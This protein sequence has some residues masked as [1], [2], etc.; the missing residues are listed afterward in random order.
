M[1]K[2]L[3]CTKGMVFGLFFISVVNLI[4]GCVAWTTVT[5]KDNDLDSVITIEKGIAGVVLGHDGL[6]TGNE[7]GIVLSIRLHGRKDRYIASEFEFLTVPDWAANWNVNKGGAI[8]VDRVQHS[9]FIQISIGDHPCEFN[10]QYFL[11]IDK[12]GSGALP[13][14]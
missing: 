7:S 4:S 14:R 2:K 9:V 5:L 1:K 8:I 3:I 13:P 11:R 6:Q 12:K 10:G